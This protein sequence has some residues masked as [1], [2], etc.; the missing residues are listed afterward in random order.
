M[1]FVLCFFDI[2]Y[3]RFKLLEMKKKYRVERVA[4]EQGAPVE[5]IETVSYEDYCFHT[6]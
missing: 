3:K 2:N 1:F 6:E 5:W 4:Y